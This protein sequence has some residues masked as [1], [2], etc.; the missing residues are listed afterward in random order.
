[1]IFNDFKFIFYFAEE[2]GWGVLA[3]Y[4]ETGVD[5]LV[6]MILSLIVDDLTWGGSDKVALRGKEVLQGALLGRHWVFLL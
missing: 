2:G 3:L 4:A 5:L 1:M 6:E